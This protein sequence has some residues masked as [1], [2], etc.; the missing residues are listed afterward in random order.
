MRLVVLVGW[1][2]NVLWWK[3]VL[4]ESSGVT[5]A[6]SV[7]VRSG[8]GMRGI[9]G[10]GMVTMGMDTMT[11]MIMSAAHGP[12]PLGTKPHASTIGAESPPIARKTAGIHS[13]VCVISRA[14]V[15]KSARLTKS[16]TTRHV[17]AS[18]ARPVHVVGAMNGTSIT[19]SV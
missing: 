5:R 11:T 3:V 18:V 15:I 17:S 7:C 10:T 4:K 6:V 8:S 16:S 19:I 9:T 13:S 14:L 12:N 2:R 1:I